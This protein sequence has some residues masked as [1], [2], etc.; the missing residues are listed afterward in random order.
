[1]AQQQI[2]GLDIGSDSIKAILTE[3]APDGKLALVRVFQSPSRG[4]RRGVVVDMD[5]V[6]GVINKLFDE[7][8]EVSKGGLKNI[9]LSV[10]GVDVSVRSSRGS[11]A[12]SRAN[13]EIHQ[14]DID[15]AV[16]ASVAVKPRSN[17]CNLHTLNQEFI[18]DGVG[19]IQDPLGMVGARLEVINLVIDAFE[20]SVKNLQKCIRLA[21]GEVGGMVFSPLA[22][23]KSVLTEKQK[24]LG[25]VLIDIGAGSTGLAIYEENKLLHTKIF[26]M[27]ANDITN[28]LALGLQVPVEVADKIKLSYGYAIPKEVPS[29]DHIDLKTINPEMSGKPSKKFVA[30]IIEARLQEICEVVNDE[31]KSIG[32]DKSLPGGAVVVGGGAKMPGVADLVQS[33]LKLASQIGVANPALFVAKDVS[34]RELLASPEHTCALGLPLYSERAKTKIRPSGK[35]AG[36]VRGLI[37]KVMP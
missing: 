24:E 2:L 3:P 8:V 1:M 32:K 23:A 5:G 37:D 10:G 22:S 31:L 13:S 27:G 19:D 18:V 20:P 16:E 35:A 14:D 21:N 29:R 7:V 25:V 4:V 34:T 9:W 11:S 12:V 26:K 33:E 15:R 17:R 28:D 6:V 30:E 36:M